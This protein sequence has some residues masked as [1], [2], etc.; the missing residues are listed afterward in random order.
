M[1][2]RSGVGPEQIARDI[3][4]TVRRPRSLDAR[5][6]AGMRSLWWIKRLSP[7]LYHTLARLVTRRALERAEAGVSQRT[8]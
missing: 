8:S 4:T 2:A 1:I 5:L 6:G 7:R 3:L